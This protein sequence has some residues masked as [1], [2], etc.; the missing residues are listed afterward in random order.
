MEAVL[1]LGLALDESRRLALAQQQQRAL[2]EIERFLG[3]LRVFAL[4]L[5]LLLQIVD[6]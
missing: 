3:F 2:D 1:L 5:G 4:A 6:A